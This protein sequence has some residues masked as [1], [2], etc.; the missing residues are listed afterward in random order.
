VRWQNLPSSKNVRDLRGRGRMAVGGGLGCG[1]VLLVLLISWLT[2][3]DPLALLETVG[4][5]AATVDGSAGADVGGPPPT[6]ELGQFA[7][8]VLGSTEAVWGELLPAQGQSYREP[9][10]NIYSGQ[11]Q[12]ACGFASAAAGPFYCPADQEVYLDLS[13]FDEL[14]QRF[15]APGDFAQAYVIAHEVAHHVQNLLGISTQVRSL[16]QRSDQ[17]GANQLSVGLE[18]QADCLAGVWGHYANREGV[19]QPGDFEEGMR[20]AAAIGDDSIQ[21]RSRGF[22]VPESFTHGSAE[23]RMAWLHRGL[24]SGDPGACDTF[25]G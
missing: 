14:G 2:G 21:R 19:I 24:E 15:G 9:V 5:G 25:G 18:L 1:G 10:L 7:T 13:F 20:A 4:G 3:A 8:K 11:V 22:V 17:A 23:Q 12:S 16:Q 6:D